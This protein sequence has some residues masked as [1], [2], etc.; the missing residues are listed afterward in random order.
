MSDTFE[1]LDLDI[2]ELDLDSPGWRVLRTRD[3][4]PPLKPEEFISKGLP[5]V[6][7]FSYS[8]SSFSG[9]SGMGDITTPI[10]LDVSFSDSSLAEDK[11]RMVIYGL[12]FSSDRFCKWA[13]SPEGAPALVS[14]FRPCLRSAIKELSLDGDYLYEIAKGVYTGELRP[15]LSSN[16]YDN[17]LIV[18][19]DSPF[20]TRA[21]LVDF[22]MTF[23]K[24]L[25]KFD[26]PVVIPDL[27]KFPDR[28]ILEKGLLSDILEDISSFLKGWEVYRDFLKLPWKRG[29]MLSG[30]PGCGK[31][32]LIRTVSEFF[33]LDTCDIKDCLDHT[34]SLRLPDLDRPRYSNV[35]LVVAP[36]PPKPSLY[37]MEDVDK[38]VT[39]QSKKEQDVGTASL[40]SI[41]KGLDG[42]SGRAGT[43]IM[44]TTNYAETLSEALINR[45]GRFDRIWEI[46]KPNAESRLSFLKYYNIEVENTTLTEVAEA[47]E[48]CSMAF[49]EEVVKTLMSSHKRR[50]FSKEECD[51]V[52]HRVMAH[53]DY[54]SKIFGKKIGF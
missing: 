53:R 2:P 18:D 1:D 7:Q 27:S 16:H 24:G 6:F 54:C 36:K 48:G 40:H 39:Y 19:E 4:K 49:V 46:P 17:V 45:P 14:G 29:Y 13:L 33:G 21:K 47:L 5:E 9:K 43:I 32:L 3:S 12:G 34:G 26:T 22:I 28:L 25:S 35:D 41:L 50:K 42:M 51:K 52:L 30:P 31:T 37:V 44:A 23:S 11:R 10:S 15:D 20:A 38:F 8:C